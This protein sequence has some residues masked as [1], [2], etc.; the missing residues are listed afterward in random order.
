MALISSYPSQVYDLH[1]HSTA[2]DG[3]LSP[4]ALIQRALDKNIHTLA[5]TDHDTVAGLEE[6]HKANEAQ[7]QPLN[8]INGVEISTGW[9]GYDIH[10][11]GLHFDPTHTGLLELLSQQR[12][13]RDQRAR[14]IGE[15]L[16][17]AGIEG[18]YEGACVYAQGAA[19]SRSHFARWLVEKNYA[20]DV[21]SVFS[22][23]L[24]RGKTGYVPNQWCSIQEAIEILHQAGGVAVLAH[25][26][27]YKMSR[28][29][30]RRLLKEFKQSQGDGM[31]VIFAQ[32]SI[33]DRASLIGLTQEFALHC[34]L[35]SDFHQVTPWCDLGR[36]LHQPEVG[37]WIWQSPNWVNSTYAQLIHE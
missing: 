37:S 34:S 12:H 31:E 20:S 24:A 13:K 7:E 18:A 1:S 17:K 14:L 28:K 9:H 8:L 10:I 6:A 2:S 23:Y 33:A 36:N 26:S 35:G 15:R 21:N 4:T 27:R 19:V 22:R 32:Q 30:L 3:Q 25:P 16:A 5:L 11:V 29:W